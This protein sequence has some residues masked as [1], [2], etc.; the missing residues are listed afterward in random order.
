[1]VEEV[2]VMVVGITIQVQHNMAKTELIVQAV[3]VEERRVAQE[4]REVQAALA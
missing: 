1:V 2:V 4:H 3:E